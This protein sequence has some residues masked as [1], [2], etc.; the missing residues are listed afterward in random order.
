MQCV[1]VAHFT[2]FLC[3]FLLF[4]SLVASLSMSDSSYVEMSCGFA[5]LDLDL[6][7]PIVK[8][9]RLE[10]GLMGGNMNQIEMIKDSEVLARRSG[11]K[12][13]AQ[14]FSGPVKSQL[15]L[16][17][18]PARL[19]EER[20][21]NYLR[22][23]P[24]HLILAWSSIEV[25]K[26]FYEI[27]AAF[28]LLPQFQP[29]QIGKSCQLSIQLFLRHIVDIP[30]LLQVLAETWSERRKSIKKLAL[31]EHDIGA[32]SHTP[33]ASDHVDTS[34]AW[35]LERFRE[36]IMKLYPSMSMASG[37]LPPL[38][39]G[40]TDL[41]RLSLLRVLIH[42]DDTLRILT[43]DGM[44]KTGTLGAG[45]SSGITRAPM[46]L[47]RI[48]SVNNLKAEVSAATQAAA[49]ATATSTSG[50]NIPTT[51]R[52]ASIGDHSATTVHDGII[53]GEYG[54][55]YSGS[56]EFRNIFQ[57]FHTSELAFDPNSHSEDFHDQRRAQI[58]LFV[59]ESGD[60]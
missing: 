26:L 25:V 44:L 41:K 8:E 30:D 45:G 37:V 52:R 15:T 23:I 32:I 27:L 4:S 51:N 19:K 38:I 7:T 47:A 49:A 60:D 59:K 40:I 50:N 3:S 13:V 31:R 5:T 11:W 53:G 17:I 56:V 36:C 10:L 57:P 28:I 58:H 39:V 29:L 21:V 12:A 18:A 54:D 9:T 35:M 34:S 6:N 48:G 14:I 16:K 55:P 24:C 2:L 20:M 46:S 1:N 42:T 33:T 22:Y 43:S